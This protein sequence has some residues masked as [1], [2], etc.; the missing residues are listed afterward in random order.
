MRA[1]PTLFWREIEGLVENRSEDLLFSGNVVIEAGLLQA[2]G[3]GDVLHR[4]AV[5]ALGAKDLGRCLDNIGP[6]HLVLPTGR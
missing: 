2:Y 4:S 3:V 6:I 1:L 5:V